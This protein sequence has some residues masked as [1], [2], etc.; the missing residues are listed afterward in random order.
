MGRGPAADNHVGPPLPETSACKTRSRLAGIGGYSK[1]LHQSPHDTTCIHSD[2]KPSTPLHFQGYSLSN[3]QSSAQRSTAKAFHGVSLCCSIASIVW[4]VVAVVAT[5]I[6]LGTL[7]GLGYFHRYYSTE[8]GCWQQ[9]PPD[10]YY[11]DAFESS[12]SGLYIDPPPRCV[13]VCS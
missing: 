13:T 12:G 1:H 2:M 10:W 5:I 8:F 6:T 9:C 3:S 4:Y 11:D 7:F